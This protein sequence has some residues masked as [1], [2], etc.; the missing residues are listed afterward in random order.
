MVILLSSCFK[1]WCCLYWATDFL[2]TGNYSY[3]WSTC[4]CG[5][6]KCP[7]VCL[8]TSE[9]SVLFWWW[10]IDWYVLYKMSNWQLLQKDSA[11]EVY[12]VSYLTNELFN[13]WSRVNLPRRRW[14]V[15]I[16]MY[17][18]EVGCRDMDWIELAQDR[19]K[20]RTFVKAIMNLRVL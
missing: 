20:W 4:L 8:P 10:L 19:D 9:A 14:E 16:E 12:L 6:T 15:N 17:L 13:K 2:K 3:H 18:Q 5:Y 11:C 1:F 7:S